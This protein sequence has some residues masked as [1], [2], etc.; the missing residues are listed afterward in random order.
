MRIQRFIAPRKT[1]IA[2]GLVMLS[3]IF[4]PWMVFAVICPLNDHANCPALTGQPLL[5][6][7]LWDMASL[8][9]HAQIAH[10]W[11]IILINALPL[12][13][14][15]WLAF[16]DARKIGFRVIGIITKVLSALYFAFMELAIL[17]ASIF[18]DPFGIEHVALLAQL[19]W[20]VMVALYILFLR[21]ISAQPANTEAN[22]TV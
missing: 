21:N 3:S 1:A 6:I 10:P 5:F 8:E 11:I 4:L 18:N 7:S 14:V 19:S 15:A 16:T 12:L 13:S 17:H 2:C 22:A 9:L 20:L